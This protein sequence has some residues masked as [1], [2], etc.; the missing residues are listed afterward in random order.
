MTEPALNLIPISHFVKPFYH[1]AALDLAL[2]PGSLDELIRIVA[3]ACKQSGW[4]VPS[5][6]RYSPGLQLPEWSKQELR[7]Q[8]SSVGDF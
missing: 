1:I 5:Q 4:N 8:S 3:A 6:P 2:Y 7:R